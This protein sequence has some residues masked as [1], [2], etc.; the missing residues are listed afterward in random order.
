MGP[1]NPTSTSVT[2]AFRD[3]TVLTT[4]VALTGLSGNGRVL[5][6]EQITWCSPHRRLPFSIDRTLSVAL[7]ASG[8]TNGNVTIRIDLLNTK[9]S[10]YAATD[11]FSARPDTAAVGDVGDVNPV[12]APASSSLFGIGLV[13]IDARPVV[14]SDPGKFTRGAAQA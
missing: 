7:D 14:A 13:C 1:F 9:G 3:Y 8:S 12:P 6:V 10:G 2:P 5:D 11:N 4:R